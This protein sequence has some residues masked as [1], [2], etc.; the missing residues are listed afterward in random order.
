VFNDIMSFALK[1]L[2]VPPTDTDPPAIRLF[3]EDAG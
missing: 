1:S 2:K 3:E